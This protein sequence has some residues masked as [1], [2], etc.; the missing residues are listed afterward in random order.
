MA[1]YVD[2]WSAQGVKNIFGTTVKVEEMQSEAGAAGTVH[3][4]LNAGALTTTYTA[5]QGLLLMIPDLYKVA[6]EGLPGV[7]NVSARALAS[8]ALSIFGDHSDVY[9][10]RQVGAAMLCESSVQEV[11]DLTPVAYCAAVEGKLPLEAELHRSVYQANEKYSNI[12]HNIDTETVAVS[13]LG[14]KMVPLLD[15]FAQIVGVK[16]K[17]TGYAAAPKALKKSNAVLIKNEG[18]LCCGGNKGDA[19]AVDMIMS[20]NAL[21]QLAATAIEKPRRISV[22]DS[23]IMRIVYTLKYSKQAEKKTEE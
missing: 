22:L 17:C 19:E 7:F 10:C 23:Y 6:G 5:S 21:T 16:V 11:M 12:I 15:D 2:Q 9:A 4:S 1:D 13:C 8:H 14:K 3:G 20:K 18:A